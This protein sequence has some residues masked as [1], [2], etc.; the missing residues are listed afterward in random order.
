MPAVSL[1]DVQSVVQD[2]LKSTAA[3]NISSPF[4]VLRSDTYY[5]CY[6]VGFS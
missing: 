4:L 3:I 5:G 1:R 6:G 2:V